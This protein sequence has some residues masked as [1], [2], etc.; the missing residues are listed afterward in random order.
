M[1]LAAGL[2][3]SVMPCPFEG[4]DRGRLIPLPPLAGEGGDGEVSCRSIVGPHGK[5]KTV[6]H[7]PNHLVFCGSWHALAAHRLEFPGL[8]HTVAWALEP[9]ATTT[10]AVIRSARW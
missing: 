3:V 10:I 7:D 1:G 9:I 5:E 4:A 6:V 2:M 8:C